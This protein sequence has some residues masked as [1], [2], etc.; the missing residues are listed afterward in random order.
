MPKKVYAAA[1]ALNKDSDTLGFFDIV[2]RVKLVN[3]AFEKQQKDNHIDTETVPTN[4]KNSF[5][6][7]TT[8]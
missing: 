1:H 3:R 6:K 2:Q 7:A 5:I 8:S 4:T